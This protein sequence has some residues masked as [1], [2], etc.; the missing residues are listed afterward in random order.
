MRRIK[1]DHQI[2]EDRCEVSRK[3]VVGDR[4]TCHEMDLTKSTCGEP[5]LAAVAVGS[6]STTEY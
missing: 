3:E 2:V 5:P 4:R 6:C 1:D